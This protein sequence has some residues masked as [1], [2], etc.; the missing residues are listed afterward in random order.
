MIDR[1]DV[2]PASQLP[3]RRTY[4]HNRRPHRPFRCCTLALDK[5]SVILFPLGKVDCDS[6]FPTMLCFLRNTKQSIPFLN[7]A[8]F[9][10][11]SFESLKQEHSILVDNLQKIAETDRKFVSFEVGVGEGCDG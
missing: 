4:H 2:F 1:I 8:L 6:V 10:T 11:R 7:R 5:R 3:M 9:S